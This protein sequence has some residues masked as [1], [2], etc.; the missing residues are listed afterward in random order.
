M[1]S[2]PPINRFLLHGHWYYDST[3]Y[4]VIFP[5]I[6]YI[7]NKSVPEMAI[8]P[9][10]INFTM[11]TMD[12]PSAVPQDGGKHV[13]EFYRMGPHSDVNVGL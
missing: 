11:D 3:I 8:D 12:F 4:I 6:P 2:V 7:S 5:Y 10:M 1:E 13:A 9:L